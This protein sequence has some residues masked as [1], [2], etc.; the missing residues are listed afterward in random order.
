MAESL[1]EDNY[2]PGPQ[3]AD[4]PD[5]TLNFEQKV[6]IILPAVSVIAVAP[7]YMRSITRKPPCIRLSFLFWVKMTAALCLLGPEL[8]ALGV[9]ANSPLRRTTTAIVASALSCLA[10][11]LVTIIVALAHL[12]SLRSLAAISVYLT[13]TVLF[14]AAKT[15]SYFARD[16]THDLAYASIAAAAIKGLLMILEEIPKRA[17]ITDE[18]LRRSASREVVS[19]FWTR[20]FFVWLNELLLLGYRS[21]I[22]M[23]DLESLGPEFSSETLH[24]KFTKIW[25]AES[26]AITLMGTDVEEAVEG[27]PELHEIWISVLETGLAVYLLSTFVGAA[28]AIG[29]VSVI[30]KANF[31]ARME[32]NEQTQVRVAKTA[33]ALAQ[34]KPLKMAGLSPALTKY[35]QKQREKELIRFKKFR[36]VTAILVVATAFMDLITPICV[37]AGG[38]FWTTWHGE[39]PA[40]D[41]Y[42]T[43]AICTLLT[44]PLMKLMKCYTNVSSTLACMFRIQKHFLAEERRDTRVTTFDPGMPRPSNSEKALT[45][46]GQ[47]T[48]K[49]KSV[50]SASSAALHDYIKIVSAS[51][52]PLPGEAAVL[53]NVS[54]CLE[55]SGFAVVLGAT[56]SGKTTFLRSL[57]GTAGVTEGFVYVTPGT[58]AYCSQTTWLENLSIRANIIGENPFDAVWYAIVTNACLLNEDL[59]QFLNGDLTLVGTGGVKLSGG[60]RQRVALARAVYARAHMVVLDDV[61]SALDTNTAKAV[62]ANLFGPRGVLKRSVSTVVLATHSVEYLEYADVSIILDGSGSVTSR[63]GIVESHLSRRFVNLLSQNNA[64]T[65]AAVAPTAPA[66]DHVDPDLSDED[67]RMQA[68]R[69][70]GDIK[71]Y[72]YYFSGIS[73]S[74]FLLWF[75]ALFLLCLAERGSDIYM[76]VWLEVAPG[77]SRYFTGYA[78]TGL[79][80][81]AIAGGVQILYFLHIVPHSAEHLHHKLLNTVTS[82]TLSFLSSS[83]VGSLINSVTIASGSAYIVPLI[84]PLFGAFYALQ[85]FYLRTSRQMR[86][87]DLEAKTPLFTYLTETAAGLEHIH[88]YGWEKKRLKRGFKALDHSQKP[89]YYMAAIQ[90]W[91][92]LSADVVTFTISITIVTVALNTTESTSM[93]GFGLS[94]MAVNRLSERICDVIFHFTKLET[95]LGAVARI[96][97]FTEMTPREHDV[98]EPVELA[99]DWPQRGE[100]VFNN[101]TATYD[102][103]SQQPRALNDMS[104]HIESGQIVLSQLTGLISPMFRI[105]NCVT[106]SRRFRRNRLA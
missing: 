76:R 5:L 59:R 91:L 28:A 22:T 56:A 55:R 34:L 92:M 95:A 77:D 14:D 72:K 43:L 20:S 53:F 90:G 15:R 98:F 30:C 35:I 73:R 64:T 84:P 70:S 97:S 32:W 25:D 105:K 100:I 75:I 19:G 78:L 6:L 24:K 37:I 83:E 66:Q 57:L 2:S 40:P 80:G 71:L 10:A 87:L 60:Q 58:I 81:A 65:N 7:F 63:R 50:A 11:L 26:A 18:A 89:F 52:A 102:P 27:L 44:E 41:V 51:I 31:S 101:V 94:L 33:K 36:T 93:A 79:I 8:T 4:K 48:E 16:D 46:P 106:V 45:W 12:Y 17:T 67:K 85:H 99:E 47:L 23:E 9:Y 96:R 29:V 74:M 54:V 82:G 88:S 68:I 103:E 38:L 13:L 61:F 49:V 3:F 86:Y 62:F 42:A 21:I 69:K 1:H 104:I 39:L